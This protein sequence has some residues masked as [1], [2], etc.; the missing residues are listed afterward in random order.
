MKIRISSLLVLIHFLAAPAFGQHK[1]A[2]SFAEKEFN[3]GTFRESDGIVKHDFQ[4]TNQ[5]KIPL[6]VNDVKASCGCTVAEWPREPVLPGKTG[7]IRVSFDPEK[8][9]GSFNKTI[10][11]NSNAD[12][13]QMVIAIK[14]V[15]IPVDMVEEVY[16]FT[17]GEIRLETIYAA[18]G[19]IYK[20]KTA[21]YSIKIFNA[22]NNKPASLT[23]RRIPA[24]LKIRVIP[25]IIEPQQEGRIELE[26]LTTGTSDWDYVVDRLDFMVN[27]QAFPNSRINVTANIREDFSE[28]SAEEMAMAPRA[29]FDSHQFDFGNITDDKVVE[30]SFKL[31]N[32]GKSNL[33]IRKVGA[34]CGCTAVQ[35]AK[36]MIPPGDSTV[37]KAVF[38]ASGREGNQKKA[39]TV[40]TNDPKRSKSILWINAIIQKSVINTKQ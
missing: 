13:P 26:Y 18:F 7:I 34:S 37:I 9:S 21:T 8:Q 27:G 28:I 4:F 22:S 35:P 10:Q 5:G 25:E 17:V 12:L 20:G 39:I 14:G 36:T 38:N 32:T 23:F 30:H 6:I 24:H 16:K 29:E 19:E 33:Y 2:I 1:P 11:I 31:T 3:F 15:V 40:I